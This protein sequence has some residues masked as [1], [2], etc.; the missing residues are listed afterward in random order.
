VDL[1]AQPKL[2]VVHTIQSNSWQLKIFG[3]AELERLK[4]NGLLVDKSIA[5]EPAASY[6]GTIK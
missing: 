1:K 5:L 4:E 6:T 2:R 3:V